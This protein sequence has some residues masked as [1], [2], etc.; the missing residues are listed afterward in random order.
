MHQS[1]AD[2]PTRVLLDTNVL[3]NACFVQDCSA[4]A[5]IS[6]LGALGYQ[7]IIDQ[8]IEHEAIEILR[9]ARIKCGLGYDPEALIAPYLSSSKILSVP[10]APFN[11]CREINIADRH[12]YSAAKNYNAWVLTGDVRFMTQCTSQGVAARMPFDVLMESALRDGKDPPLQYIVRYAGICRDQGSVF[13][14]VTP[15]NWAGMENVGTF[16]VC[17][18]ENVLTLAYDSRRLG[19]SLSIRGGAEGFAH[20]PIE[21][22]SHDLVVCGS[23]KLPQDA[24][25]GKASLRI[26]SSTGAEKVTGFELSKGPSASAPGSVTFGHNVNRRNH[27]NGYIRCI[28]VSPNQMNADTWKALKANPDSTPDPASGNIL[29]AALRKIH[30]VLGRYDLPTEAQ[31]GLA[32][33]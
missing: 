33:L 21:N 16:T 12:V 15:G 3:L 7:P 32:W 27:W 31:M 2:L 1:I 28:I 23:F 10:A 25:K 30:V 13:A 4:R 5:A 19:W 22:G 17:E 9:R 18:I 14:R 11:A 24:S 26:Y 8:S 6:R 20:L 29:E